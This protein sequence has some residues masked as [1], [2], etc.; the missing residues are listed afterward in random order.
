MR[1]Q[2]FTLLEIRDSNGHK[3]NRKC[4]FLTGF[5]LI[6]LLVVISII[7][8]L[9]V[10]S[11]VFYSAA[12]AKGRDAA[13]KAELRQIQN[14]LVIYQDNN[15]GLYPEYLTDLVPEYLP[16]VPTDPKTG[17]PYLY[18]SS[19]DGNF[20]ELNAILELNHDNAADIDGGN[21]PFPV[22]EIGNDLTLLP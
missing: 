10:V 22:Y 8:I 21:Q 5:T 4:K 17:N 11:Y 9:V 20:Y 6:E 13:R 14:A 15:V 12:R 1:K 2:G 3:K 19:A 16:A 7:A 18:A